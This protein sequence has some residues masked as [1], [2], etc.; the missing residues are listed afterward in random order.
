[1][2]RRFPFRFDPTFRPV[3]ALLGV[4]PE[5]AWVAV[6]EERLVVRFGPWRLATARENVTGVE[7]GGPYRWW[8]VIGPHLS[9]VDAGVTFGSSTAAGLCVRFRTPVP[10]LAPGRWLRHRAVTITV[11]DPDDLAGVLGGAG[12]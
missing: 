2:S 6:D 11:T 3:L 4:R 9:L 12:R 7:R 5:T 10:A 8:R 1:M